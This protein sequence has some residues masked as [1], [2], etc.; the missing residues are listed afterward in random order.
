[1]SDSFSSDMGLL[2]RIAP[3]AKMPSALEL[4]AFSFL[5]VIP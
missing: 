3:N 4:T 2:T 5:V 1:M